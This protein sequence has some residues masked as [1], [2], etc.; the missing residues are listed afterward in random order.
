MITHHS[1]RLV[2]LTVLPEEVMDLGLPGWAMGIARKLCIR[3]RAQEMTRWSRGCI[4][5]TS[6]FGSWE[7]FFFASLL[8]RHHTP[9]RLVDP[10]AKSVAETVAQRDYPRK[11]LESIS[12]MHEKRLLDWINHF[13]NKLDRKFTG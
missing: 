6:D 11:A 13:Q 7:N 9:T 10:E 1:R 3:A 2:P 4:P 5:H 12:S 8:Y